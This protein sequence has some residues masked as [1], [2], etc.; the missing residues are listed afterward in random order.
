MAHSSGH[1]NTGTLQPA[2]VCRRINLVIPGSA[3]P[4]P[5]ISDPPLI[6]NPPPSP[7]NPRPSAMTCIPARS[8]APTG[9]CRDAWRP[10]RGVAQRNVARRGC[11]TTGQS[12]GLIVEGGTWSLGVVVRVSSLPCVVGCFS[13]YTRRTRPYF[14]QILDFV[15]VKFSEILGN[16]WIRPWCLPMGHCI[17]GL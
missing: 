5:A 6:F 2:H 13:K 11:T 8:G 4:N 16:S 9:D 15:N 10:D 17:V 1:G 14:W 12:G 3:A 7:L